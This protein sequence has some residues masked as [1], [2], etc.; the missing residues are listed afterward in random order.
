MAIETV[1]LYVLW[2][3]AVGVVSYLAWR[4]KWATDLQLTEAELRGQKMARKE[5]QRKY[6]ELYDAFL[7]VN[8]LNKDLNK[9][10][11]MIPPTYEDCADDMFTMLHMWFSRHGIA[12]KYGIS[13]STV[14]YW[15]RKKQKEHDE[16][17]A[18][19]Q[20]SITNVHQNHLV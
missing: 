5:Q 9:K 16:A 17:I 6:D 12:E 15:L 14:C 10:I 19:A 7:R 2:L 3:I 18:N 1:S 13:Y 20:K 11:Q 8:K 4:W